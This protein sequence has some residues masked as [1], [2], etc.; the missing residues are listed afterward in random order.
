VPGD[1]FPIVDVSSWDV[2]ADETSGAEE[3]YWLRDPDGQQ[4]WLFKAVRVRGDHIHGE[5]WAEKAVAH[6]GRLL[7]VP[8]AWVEL[9]EMHGSRGSIS[10]DLCPTFYELQHGQILLEDRG[11]AGYEHRAGGREHPGHSL[12][13]IRVAL[14][15]VDALPPD[16]C[17]LPFE[18]SAFDVFAGFLVLDAWVAN[19]DRHDN[20]WAVLR[21]LMSSAEAPMRLCGSYDHASSLGFSITDD[22]RRR[23]LDDEEAIKRWCG[24]GYA[25][26]FDLGPGPE[27]PTLVELAVEGLSLASNAAGEYWARQL[28]E[29]DE[30]EVRRV[31]DR[32]PRMSDPARRFVFEVLGVNR[33]RVLDAVA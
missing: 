12:E 19:T 1:Q 7:R 17:N 23:L 5:D 15:A 29:V 6:L 2:I 3:K 31:L 27:R 25:D 10:A 13:N 14:S 24:R 33:R 32:I 11:A 4:R 21:P 8:C 18:G 22:Q 9:A 26:R 16:G 20:N 30:Q 28:R